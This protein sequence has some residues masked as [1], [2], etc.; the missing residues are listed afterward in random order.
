VRPSAVRTSTAVAL[1]TTCAFVMTMPSARMITPEPELPRRVTLTTAGVA[2]RAT[3]MM[4]C[5][6]EVS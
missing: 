1:P 2:V 6:S 3:R 5:S 4:T